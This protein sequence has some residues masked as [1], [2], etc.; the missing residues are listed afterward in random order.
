MHLIASTIRHD[1]E[2]GCWTYELKF[3]NGGNQNIVVTGNALSRAELRR[4][5]DEIKEL[6]GCS[7]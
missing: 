7:K 4:T 3:A 5:V 1:V 6:L 2:I